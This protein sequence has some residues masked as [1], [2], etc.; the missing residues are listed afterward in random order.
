MMGKKKP[1]SKPREKRT[2]P[3]D[4]LFDS[5]APHG[6]KIAAFLMAK[7]FV[8]SEPRLQVSEAAR[9]ISTRRPKEMIR[10][11]LSKITRSDRVRESTLKEI[12]GAFN[13]SVEEMLSSDR[14]DSGVS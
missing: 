6:P 9:H 4:G 3:P 8:V 12:A 5:Y 10:Q 7:G 1:E 11:R 2:A 14:V 13:V